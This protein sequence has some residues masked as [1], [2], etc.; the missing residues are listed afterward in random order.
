MKRFRKIYLE[1]SNV[2]NLRCTFCPGTRRPP[3]F[4]T[5]EDFR[6]LAQKLRGHTRFLYFHLMGEP[7]LHPELRTF[8]SMAGE[9]GFRVI[10]TTNGT[11]LPERQE[12]LLDAP[13]LH[14][15]NL[16]LQAF[17]ANT[18]PGG[19]ED[20]LAGCADFAAGCAASG[21]LCSLRLWNGGGAEA[22]NGEIEGFLETRFPKPWRQGRGSTLA[23]RIFLEYG[24]TF[25]WPDMA[26]EDRGE[27]CFCHGLRDHVGVLCDGTV[28]PCC[29]DHEGDIPLGNLLHEPL[30]E[31]LQGPRAR[32]VYDGFSRRRAAETLCRR[33]GYARRFG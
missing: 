27:G 14:R 31:I 21:K 23:E 11:L 1:I 13:A 10:L 8:L 32:A 18:M 30:E 22:L 12:E 16:S 2:C 28:V 17:E 20:Y 24:E 6:T 26:A 15:V 33:C 29:L 5:A 3:R 9:L 19:L 25:D 7:L 4:M